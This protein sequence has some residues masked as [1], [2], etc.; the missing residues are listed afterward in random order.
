[1]ATKEAISRMKKLELYQQLKDEG[2]STLI[3]LK[4]ISWSKATYYRWLSR[5]KEQGW[6]GLKSK[7]R[8]PHHLRKI[9]WTRKDEQ[10]VLHLRKHFPIWGKRKIWKLLTQDQGLLISESTVGRILTKLILMKKV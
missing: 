7:S 8:R 3:A 6:Q 1:M 10:A 5:Y 2:C 4:A 9:Q